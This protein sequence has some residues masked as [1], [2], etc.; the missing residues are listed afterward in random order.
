MTTRKTTSA[1]LEEVFRDAPANNPGGVVERLLRFVVADLPPAHASLVAKEFGRLEQ[2]TRKLG[3]DAS[4]ADILARA[5]ELRSQ[6][7]AAV[8]AQWPSSDACAGTAS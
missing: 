3:G 6:D 1:W 7:E 5:R 4:A 2:A 8:L